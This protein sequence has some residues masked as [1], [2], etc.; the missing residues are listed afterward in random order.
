VKRWLR[1]R[2]L[3]MW[4]I[5]EIWEIKRPGRLMRCDEEIC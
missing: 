1:G 2:K 5:Q 4:Q 3:E